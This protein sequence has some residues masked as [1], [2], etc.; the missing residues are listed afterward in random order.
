MKQVL[1]APIS[2]GSFC[3]QLAAIRELCKFNYKP[4][5]CL[6][7]S[8]GSVTCYCANAGS[9]KESG[10]NRIINQLSSTVFIT[11][12][13]NPLMNI[14]PR[15]LIGYYAGYFYKSNPDPDKFL[16]K[17][18]T[19]DSIQ[20]TEIWVGAIN[21]CS[22]RLALFCNQSYKKANIQGNHFNVNMF[23]SEPLRYLSGDIRHIAKSMIASCSIPILLNSTDIG[24]NSYIDCGTKFATPLTALQEEIVNFG[25]K[26][27]AL[28]ITY[29]SG[30]NVEA[31]L[32]VSED[33]ELDMA[34]LFQT[35]P[36]HVVRG[37]VMADRSVAYRII[38]SKANNTLMYAV[39][40]ISSLDEI[41][42][43]RH[44]CNF[45]LIEIYPTTKVEVDI[46]SFTSK[47]LSN[48]VDKASEILG[49]RI[50]WDGNEKLFNNVSK[51]LTTMMK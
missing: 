6:A 23:N 34:D 46:F 27:D 16:E 39:A 40:P 7:G 43:L 44:K 47:Q 41:M 51:I 13:D 1:V 3:V 25:E 22:G 15:D 10:I 24:K 5:I 21:K 38:A 28:H 20:E 33:E 49:I 45:S 26:D 37:M 9:W 48:A 12:N 19:K 18:F 36:N 35:I 14:M 2:G 29:L 11:K 32:D 31:K 30:Y 17:F 42:S 4:N 8:G 50:W